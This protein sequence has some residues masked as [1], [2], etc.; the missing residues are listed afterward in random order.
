MATDRHTLRQEIANSVTH[1]IGTALS[2]AGLTL[3]VVLAS[4]RGSA[5]H[6]VSVAVYGTT[7]VLLY[8]ASTLYHAIQHDGA[9]RV[10]K[11]LD[12]AAIFLLIAGT[13]TPFTLVSLRGPWGWS[14]FGA[15]W[16]LAAVGIVFKLF[17][18]GRYEGFSTA[19]YL[20]MGW[21]IAVALKPLAMALPT[22][23]IVLLLL[24]GVAYSAGVIFYVQ[25]RPYAH[26]VWHLFVIAGSLCH[27]FSILL[28]VLPRT[29]AG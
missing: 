19:V 4:L 11:I 3:L 8:L 9:K 1:G 28:Y 27:F 13:Y 15:V 12:H 25:K 26:A 10:L 5:R 22:G 7:L 17:F 6:V 18:T 16:G 24:G 2:V 14:L 29:A 23:G 21:I 20:L